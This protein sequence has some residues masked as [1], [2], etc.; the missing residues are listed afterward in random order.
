M[1]TLTLGTGV[2]DHHKLIGTMLR[3]T[4]ATGKAKKIFYPCYKNFD[5]EKFEEEIKKRLSSV[6]DFE[7]FHLAFK[8]TLDRFAPSKQ[9]VVRNNNQPFMTK[10]L[11]KGIMKR[12]KLKNKFNNERNTKT[13]SNYKQQRNY[14]SNLLKES[15]TPPFN[16]LN[17]KDV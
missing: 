6:L 4:L 8:T 17:V 1:N 15:K 13:W 7:S 10:V 14:Y 9:K 11:R 12:S 5:N 16:N 2:S 3:S